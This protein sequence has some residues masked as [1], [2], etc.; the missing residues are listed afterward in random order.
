[1]LMVCKI[2]VHAENF[3]KNTHTLLTCETKG[4]R[5][6]YWQLLKQKRY[7]PVENILRNFY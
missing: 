7:D 3:N 6:I 2:E 1:M 5:N 4:F